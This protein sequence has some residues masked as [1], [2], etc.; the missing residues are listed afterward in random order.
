VT[1][2]IQFIEDIMKP[3][4]GLSHMT[5]IEL[6]PPQIVTAAAEAG[7]KHVGVRLAPARAGEP[8]HPM[9]GDTPM[10]RETLSRLADTGVTVL[11]FDILR[12]RA[13]TDI[14]AFKP[15]L[16]AGARLGAKH[17]LVAVDDADETV[18][19]AVFARACDAGREFDLT[20]NLEFMPWTGV[21]SL[22]QAQRFIT[23]VDRPNAR[24]LIDAIHLDRSDGTNDEVARVPRRMLSY[25]QICD[26][27]A[28]RPKDLDGMLFQAR[29][30]RLFPGEG[31]LDLLG[32]V[33]ALPRDLPLS[34]EIPRTELA[35]TVSAEERARRAMAGM[36]ALLERLA[37]VDA[38]A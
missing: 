24:I 25:A 30:E 19:P 35:K 9:L 7:F 15:V 23:R 6:T 38:T 5:A 21:K 3:I 27:P 8:Q 14:D 10:M 20:M 31:G 28:E 22:V 11:D 4:I 1:A 36:Q 13:D 12:L 16:E 33:R 18:M 32:L 37:A 2:A 29:Y 17:L 26:A 34:L